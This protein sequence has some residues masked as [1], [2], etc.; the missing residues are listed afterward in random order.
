VVVVLEKKSDEE[1]VLKNPDG[2][3]RLLHNT[4]QKFIWLMAE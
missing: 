1:T 3:A 4:S 2:K